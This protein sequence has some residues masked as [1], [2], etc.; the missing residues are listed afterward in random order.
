MVMLAVDEQSSESVGLPKFIPVAVH[1]VL[2]TELLDVSPEM[3]RLGKIVGA[4]SITLDWAK[5]LIGISDLITV[6]SGA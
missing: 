5:T 3:A 1:P 6:I 2:T 4:Y